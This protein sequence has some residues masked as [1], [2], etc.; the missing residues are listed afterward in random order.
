MDELESLDYQ[1]TNPI[2]DEQAAEKAKQQEQ[3][4]E[5]RKQQEAQRVEEANQ[6]QTIQNQFEKVRDWKT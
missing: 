5:Y 1:S 4:L 6:Q 3:Y 2:S